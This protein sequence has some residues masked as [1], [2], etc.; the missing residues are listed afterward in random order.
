MRI[1][2]PFEDEDRR[3]LEQALDESADVDR[4]A[5]VVARAGAAELLAQA[6]GRVVPTTMADLRA[7][8]IFLLIQQGITLAETE[9][10]VAAIFKVP[11]P[12]A[13]RLV[14]TAVARYS[15]EL[16]GDI[17]RN[18]TGLVEEAR[19]DPSDLR[20]LVRVPTVFVRER[21]MEVLGSLDLPDPVSAQRGPLWSFADET[22][23]AL[24]LALG[25]PE[26]QKPNE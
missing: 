17:L 18:M 10:L 2:L 11:S 16:Q 7:Y 23:Q 15:V 4:I 19:W 14:N 5:H 13:K 25:L 20:W 3:R 6:T 21:M 26:K 1:D 22:Y 12:T 8:R 9:S 24:R